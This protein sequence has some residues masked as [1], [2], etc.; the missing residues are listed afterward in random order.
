LSDQ[1]RGEQDIRTLANSIIQQLC[2]YLQVQIGVLYVVEGQYLVPMG[3]Y[4]YSDLE[5]IERF[6][7][8]EGL[9]GQ[10]ALEKRPLFVADVPNDYLVVRSGLGEIAPRNILLFPFMYNDRVV[11]VI[12]LGA[13]GE[14]N[15]AQWEFIETALASIAVAF[16][17]A[18][19]RTRIDELLAQTQQQAEDLQAQEEE[20][21]VA[22]EE[23]ENQTESLRVSE[24]KLKEQKSKL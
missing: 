9:V 7:F 18:Q 6:E 3:Q 24:T 16:N 5:P 15:Q 14:F 2:H 4:A 11:G 23:L 13:L 1:I 20:L 21:R 22:N 12:E 8:G 19:A 10:T 17:T